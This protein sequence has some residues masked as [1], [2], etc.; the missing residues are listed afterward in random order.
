[1]WVNKINGIIEREIIRLWVG[2]IH[3]GWIKSGCVERR[4]SYP[5]R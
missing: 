1:M 5:T 4:K 2:W 3:M